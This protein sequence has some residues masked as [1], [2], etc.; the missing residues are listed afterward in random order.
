MEYPLNKSVFT[1]A[2]VDFI[3][4]MLEQA[5]EKKFLERRTE[6]NPHLLA[7]FRGIDGKGISPKWNIKIYNLR[8]FLPI[9]SG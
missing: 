7:S 2:E 8:C 1:P 4:D 5:V 3:I 9:S 6:N